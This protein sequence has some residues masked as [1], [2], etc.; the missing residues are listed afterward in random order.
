ML[1]CVRPVIDYLLGVDR[2]PPYT[3][4]S[5]LTKDL[6]LK[7]PISLMMLFH[8]TQDEK[9]KWY[10][11]PRSFKEVRLKEIANM[12]VEAVYMS[13]VGEKPHKKGDILTF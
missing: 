3:V 13:R 12:R 2:L 7:F 5:A 4:R 8:L 6:V 9:G 11:P 1:W 10:A